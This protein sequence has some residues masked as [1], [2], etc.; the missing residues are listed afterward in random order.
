M[1]EI[2]DCQDLTE[3]E[4]TILA[5]EEEKIRIMEAN[6]RRM[7]ARFPGWAPFANLG[8][9]TVQQV[10]DLLDLAGGGNS[11]VSREKEEKKTDLG[12]DFQVVDEKKSV[13]GGNSEPV[14]EEQGDDSVL[15]ERARR[16]TKGVVGRRRQKMLR[17]Q[18]EAESRI[19]T[20]ARQLDNWLKGQRS[21]LQLSVRGVECY[22]V[23]NILL[24]SLVMR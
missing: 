17:R 10:G 11:H 18:Q 1:A 22:R 23:G 9:G 19:A 3:E 2:A 21:W 6:K 14:E 16:W 8:E 15:N 12:R 7:A 5:D 24:H 13:L 4:L 20:Y